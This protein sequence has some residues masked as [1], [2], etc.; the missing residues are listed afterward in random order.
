VGAARIDACLVCG[1]K[2]HDFDFARLEILKLLAEHERIRVRVSQDYSDLAAI[3]HADVLVTY[4]CDVRPDGAQQDA[5]GEFVASGR[6]WFALHGTNSLIDIRPDGRIETPRNAP[7]FVQLLG[8]QFLAH[9]PLCDYRVQVTRPEHPLVRGLDSF[10]VHDELYLAE[11]HG[12][13]E[14]LLHTFFGGRA[15][16]GY[17]QDEWRADEPRPVLYLHPHGSGAVLYLTLGHCRG[18]YDMLPLMQ[19]YPRVERCSWES[20]VY[21]E[22]LRRGIRWAARLDGAYG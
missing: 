22:L 6:R 17:P 11:M 21:Y 13:N 19:E 9:P 4:T 1:G 16:R 12:T 2:Y 3:E 20:P 15:Q 10:V 14:V 18:R 8:S 7:K 5:L